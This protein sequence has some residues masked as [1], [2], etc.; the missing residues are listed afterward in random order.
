MGKISEKV[1]RKIEEENIR[2]IGRFSFVLKKW[3]LWFLFTV[4]LFLGGVGL[5]VSLYLFESTEVL[6]LEASLGELPKLLLLA[7]PL[8]W[9]VVTVFFLVVLYLNFRYTE[10]GYKLS[11]RKIF[12][13]NIIGII[14]VASLLT[15]LGLPNSFRDISKG[16]L[17]SSFVEKTDPR[18]RVWTRPEDGYL[19]GTIVETDPSAMVVTIESLDSEVWYVS[20]SQDVVRKSVDL[21][22]VGQKIKVVGKPLSG[23][24]FDAS[25]ILPWEGRGR[26]M[27]E[28]QQ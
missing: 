2:P 19:A 16:G 14:F 26:K 7:L 21:N 3:F 23:R 11:F 27:Q 9:I 22:L 8:F 20:F 13:I 25:D 1:V 6:S 5:S 4:N 17:P 18:Y 10:G 24:R 15:L 28:F 12:V